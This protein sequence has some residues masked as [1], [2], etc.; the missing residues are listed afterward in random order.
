MH[1]YTFMDAIEIYKPILW[2]NTDKNL[3]P[4]NWDIY[5]ITIRTNQV[6]KN[7]YSQ[8]QLLT[9]S[10]YMGNIKYYHFFSWYFI[11]SNHIA[12]ER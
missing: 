12:I 2:I 6:N 9:Y 11:Y 3:R 10:S 4:R 8:E 5:T 7:Q 1:E